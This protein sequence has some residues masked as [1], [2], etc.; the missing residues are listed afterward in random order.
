[1]R[2]LNATP[3]A[4]L[5]TGNVRDQATIN[6][7]TAAFPSPFAGINSTYTST[8]SRATL[9]E[10]FPEFGTV[11]ETES[12]GYSSYE[13]LQ[14]QVTKR[15]TQGYLLKGSYTFSKLMDATEFL[16]SADSNP[17]YGISRY[18]RPNILTIDGVW[19]LPFG[20]GHAFASTLP[21]WANAAV[22]GWE[23]AG[24]VVSQSGDPLTWGNIIFN[25]NINDI[26]LS[27]SERSVSRWFNTS[28]GF[29]TSSSAQLADNVR[30]FPLRF[31]G[32]RGPGIVQVNM[33][34]SK[35][36]PI[37]ERLNLVLRGDAFNALNHANYTDPNLT[38]TSGGF[39]Q[40]TNINGYAREV[41]VSAKLRF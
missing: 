16:N 5:S 33:S 38:V 7:L 41:Q 15:F 20:K 4:F 25:G 23:L 14:V 3:N 12:L 10:P 39:G 19:E 24:S 28:A 6:Y 18:N 22:G 27:G 35:S 32:V 11:G 26:N 1:V 2:Q 31:A 13:S 9:L 8:I 40:I 21:A 30:T 29:V 36:F 34:V 37:H 17:W